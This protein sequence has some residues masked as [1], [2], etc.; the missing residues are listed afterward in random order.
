MNN[1]FTSA[2]ILL[3]KE[4]ELQKWS[5][6]AC[7][8]YTSEPHYWNSVEE[9]VG[10]TYST[11]NL[12]FP[13][14]YLETLDFDEKIASINS[15]MDKYIS[16]GIFEEHKDSILYIE[17]TDRA[18]NVRKGLI[19][20]FDLEH[21][22]YT[23]GVKLAVR[24]TEGTVL[25]RIPPR[26]RIRQDAPLE[27]PHIMVLIDDKECEIIEK[28]A[29][30]LGS[31][32]KVYDFNLMQDSGS[33][34]GYKLSAKVQKEVLDKLNH[35]SSRD[36]FQNRYGLDD[37]YPVL[38]YAVGD[39]NH[40]LATAKKCYED[41]K[42]KI[43]EEKAKSHPARYALAELV[44][45]HSDALEFEAIHRIVF[46][47]DPQDLIAKMKEH[48]SI[49]TDTSLGGAS[50]Q[51]LTYVIDGVSTDIVIT[52]PTLNLA[53]GSLTE[54][55]DAYTKDNGGVVD[56]IHGSEVVCELSKASDSI[57]FILESM[58]KSDLFKTVIFDD[59]LPRKTF[60]M[61]HAWDKRFYLEVRKIK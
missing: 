30:N 60:S 25:D 18:G 37:N 59:A 20:A 53:V 26:V 17:R 22:D 6:V 41:L 11:L 3:P 16:D 14:I 5:V 29:D 12:I 51:K 57:G 23:K 56:Y 4:I 32:T 35:Y 49:S 13:E 19:G 47:V 7:D 39:G 27:L 1:V 61:G 8:Q 36:E 44:N 50:G 24:A 10:D 33:I 45:V 52:N 21:Y 42:A 58:E 48:F 46:K 55:L 38:S 54:F 40:S 9:F 15:Y 43:G 28:I 31:A 34:K 2:D